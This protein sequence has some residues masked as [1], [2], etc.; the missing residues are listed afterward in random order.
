MRLHPAS[1]P[2]I[3]P[4]IFCCQLLRNQVVWYYRGT[5]PVA[6]NVRTDVMAAIP[7]NADLRATLIDS[8]E[9]LAHGV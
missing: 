8:L 4:R 2:C 9:Y 3:W 6:W 5:A 7:H 1:R